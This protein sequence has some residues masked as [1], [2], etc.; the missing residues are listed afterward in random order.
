MFSARLK[1]YYDLTKYNF[2]FSVLIGL[3]ISIDAGIITF[4]TFGMLVG[5]ISYRYFQNNQY[6]FY[7][8]LGISKM[9]LISVT[10]LINL[11]I[12]AFFLLLLR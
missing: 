3:I 6:Y 12:S 1:Y 9:A 7:Y 5:L 4:G 11:T 10:W 2:G 8:N